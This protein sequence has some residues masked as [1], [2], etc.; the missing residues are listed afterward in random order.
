MLSLVD[1]LERGAIN[2]EEE[3]IQRDQRL[4]QEREQSLLKVKDEETAITHVLTCMMQ[5][6]GQLERSF[7][8]SNLKKSI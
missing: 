8:A 3:A 2:R 5:L 7:P 4:R 1:F 6:I